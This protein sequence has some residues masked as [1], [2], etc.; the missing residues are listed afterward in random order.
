MANSINETT[1]DEELVKLIGF[2]DEYIDATFDSRELS[3]K[4]RNYYD[5]YQWTA[6]E[7]E[8]LRAR[9]QPCIT[10]NRIKPKV[11]FLR[12][13]EMQTRT[14]PKAFPRNP[15]DDQSAEVS[16][17]ML[18][19][20]SDNN[21]SEKKISKGF[22][23]YLVEGTQGH[24]VIVEDING[25][26]EIIHNVIAWDRLWYDPHSREEDFS[27]ARYLGTL[28]WMD[29]AEGKE[30]YPDAPDTVWVLDESGTGTNTDDTFEDRPSFFTDKKRKRVRVFFAYFLKKGVW[31]YSIFTSGGFI[32]A[33]TPSPY[34]DDN[35]KPEPQFIFESAFVDT[36]GDRYG[37]V[38]AYLDMQDEINKRRSKYLHLMSVR[39]TFGTKGATGGGDSVNKLKTQLANPDGHA[40]FVAGEFGKDFGVLPTGD[41]ANGQAQLLQEAKQEID[42]QGANAALTGTD[43]RHL[44]GRAFQSIQQGGSVEIGPLFD[45]NKECKNRINR[46]MFSRAKQFWTEERWIRV[47]D[48]EDKLKFTGINREITLEDQIMEELGEVPPQ[49]QGDPRLKMVVGIDNPVNE[50]DVDIIIDE[51]VNTVTLQQ[52]QFDVLARL[53]EAN[54]AAVP[55]ELVIRASQLRNKDELLKLV[56]GGDEDQ[57]EALRQ[58][59]AQEQQE[60]N[61]IL[62]AAAI[63]DIEE[64]K[65]VAAKNIASAGKSEAET[66]QIEIETAIDMQEATAPKIQVF[67]GA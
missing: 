2:V 22:K 36:D 44:S 11:Q 56:Q 54:P 15:N 21:K 35:G 64:K 14:D 66:E 34:I 30:Q 4:C 38:A 23:N 6:D 3:T 24:E 43:P 9:K 19:Y 7:R 29:K 63:A 55:F 28:Q 65:S 62:K 26:F 48:N 50:L 41:M 12:G 39:Q 49:F 10:N 33:P 67:E 46:M 31:H 8:I 17:D 20:I 32:K 61:E 51:G 18:R 25:K 16:T 47:T 13:M 5:G 42:A 37:E 53:Y 57:Q 58:A 27:D 59:Q 1:K 45:G 60:Q 40:E 52:E